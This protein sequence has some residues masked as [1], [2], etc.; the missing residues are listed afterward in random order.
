[1]GRKK[2]VEAGGPEGGGDQIGWL[3]LFSNL[4]IPKRSLQLLLKPA[5]G[6]LPAL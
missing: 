5:Q 2:E 1:M 3:K 6:Q 4:L